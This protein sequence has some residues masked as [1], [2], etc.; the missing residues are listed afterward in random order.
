MLSIALGLLGD[1]G[2]LCIYSLTEFMTYTHIVTGSHINS[3]LLYQMLRKNV[4]LCAGRLRK[5]KKDWKASHTHNVTVLSKPIS[6]TQCY[7]P[8]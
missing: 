4:G 5:L 8:F 6:H 2:L 7:C 1:E 3:N